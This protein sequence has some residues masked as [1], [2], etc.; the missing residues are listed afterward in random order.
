M[1]TGA[2]AGHRGFFH[3][4]ACYGSDD[5]FVA[6]TVPFVEGGPRRG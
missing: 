6:V 3:E 5:D 1:R 2:A 4:A